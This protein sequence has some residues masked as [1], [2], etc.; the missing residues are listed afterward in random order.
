V[1][2]GTVLRF[3]YDKGFGFIAPD[4]P[5]SDVF[6]HITALTSGIDPR[7]VRPDVRVAYDVIDAG[8]G[9]KAVNVVMLLPQQSG[10]AFITS[11]RT[12]PLKPTEA[13]WRE[14]WEGVFGDFLERARANGWVSDA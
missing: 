1:A 13:A 4:A 12:G 6:L 11:S 10:A 9:P 3:D 2:T 5:G 14:L 8:R 7:S